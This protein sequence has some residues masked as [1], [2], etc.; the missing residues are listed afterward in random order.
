M[1]GLPPVTTGIPK[2]VDAELKLLIAIG[3]HES[4]C[5]ALRDTIRNLVYRYQG[6]VITAKQ[7]REKMD[8]SLKDNEL[9]SIIEEMRD[10]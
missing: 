5:E 10:E 1:V 9:S 6:N 8:E 7:V 4:K 2:Q 3:L